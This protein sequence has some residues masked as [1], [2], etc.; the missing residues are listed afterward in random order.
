MQVD[1][2]NQMFAKERQGFELPPE[3]LVLL[4][5][6][7][8]AGQQAHTAGNKGRAAR[9]RATTCARKGGQHKRIMPQ[10]TSGIGC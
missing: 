10:Q 2:M 7:N 6:Q 3:Q 1:E 8:T 5:L 9:Q 4:S